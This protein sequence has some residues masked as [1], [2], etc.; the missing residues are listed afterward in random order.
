GF[1]SSG[2]RT[3]TLQGNNTGINLVGAAIIDSVQVP[4]T[5]GVLGNGTTA[6]T[7][8]GN[9]SWG[10]T[11][12]NTFSGGVTINNGVLGFLTPTSFGGNTVNGP[13]SVLVNGGGSAAFGPALTGSIQT[14][15]NR[16]SPLSTGTV[17]LTANTSEN[18]NLD[19]G[20]GGAT[21]PGAFLG[22]YGNVTYTGT[23]TPFGNAY[24]LGGGGGVLS[25]PNGGLSGPRQLIIGGGG[26]GT[27]FANNPNLNGAVVLGGVSD[28]SGGTVLNT[29][30]IV[31]ATNLAALGSGPL[32]FQ[33]GFYR[34]VDATDITLASDGT[35]AREIRI[36]NET[37]NNVQTANVD[38]ARGVNVTFSKTFGIATPVGANQGQQSFTKWGAGALTLA[39]GVNLTNSN[40][41]NTLAT[42]S[43]TLTVERGTLA[44][45]NN[46]TNFNGLIQVG[47]NNGG[48]GTLKLGANNVFAN[49]TAQF[50]T[51]SIIDTFNGSTID[52]AGFSDTVR[53]VR[54][55]ASIV[56]TGAPSANLTVGT[57]NEIGIL[58]GTLEGNFTLTKGG[59]VTNL[60]GTG[61]TINSL[62]LWGANNP[63]FTG[64]FVVNAGGLR[65][66]ADGTL[67]AAN[68]PFK[69]DKITLNNNAVLLSSGGTNVVIGA[70][71]GITLGA[72]GGTLWQFNTTA[73]V[74]NSPITGPGA[75]TIAD[76]VGAIFLTNNNNNWAGG[77]TINN[78]NAAN[79][80]LLAIGAGGATGSLPAGDVLF[81]S[82]NASATSAR[83]LFFKSTDM[84]VPNNFNGP[85]T[86]FQ[87]GGGTTTLTGNNTTNQTTVVSGGKLRADFTNPARTPI[88]TGS[89]L[90]IS[91]GTFEYVAPAGDNTFRFN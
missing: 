86:I 6:I 9:G 87:I 34:A 40:G 91:G 16:I 29:G 13:A 20:A 46:P 52:L 90:Q 27:G 31:S 53:I 51:A 48:V 4:G 47:S 75:L 69:A 55:M 39:N 89:A 70:N 18:L 49:T 73:M 36:G 64:K 28:Y 83:L 30:A 54:G 23:L 80:G 84:T 17:A 11:G 2:N 74:V 81:N 76:D 1:L 3:L 14:A 71:H 65:I 45:L 5:S 85:G 35:S 41:S 63:D 37:S 19:G 10:L 57:A 61:A 56:N 78:N 50:S 67:G 58:G 7:K 72:G 38:V 43:G 42:N 33:G 44:L 25:M 24:R 60:F 21:L 32:K 66:R 15:L 77:T 79:R 8:N 68:E 88:S 26:P 59:T 12:N 62:E 22:A 82:A